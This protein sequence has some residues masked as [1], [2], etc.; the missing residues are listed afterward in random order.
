[1]TRTIPELAPS[2]SKF[3]KAEHLTLTAFLYCRSPYTV[4]FRQ[5]RGTKL[6]PY[7]P[8]SES[9]F[10]ATGLKNPEPYFPEI[11]VKEDTIHFRFVLEKL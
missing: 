1:M 7:S 10:Q 2:S 9:Y 4:A 11:S 3:Q 5:N 6:E 8:E